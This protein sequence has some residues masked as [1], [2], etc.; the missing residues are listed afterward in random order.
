QLRRDARDT[1]SRSVRHGRQPWLGTP[2]C[3]PN[4]M[5]MLS[6]LDHYLAT[7]D[8]DGI[9]LHQYAHATLRTADD[10]VALRIATDYPWSEQISIEVEAAPEQQ[11]A[12]ALRIP[13]WCVA[14]QVTVN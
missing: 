1:S 5:R 12:I 3:P 10:G 2:C 9:Q 13:A 8:H 7:G 6:S 11:Q 4:I 14:A